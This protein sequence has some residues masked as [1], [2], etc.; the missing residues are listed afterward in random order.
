[1]LSEDCFGQLGEVGRPHTVVD[2]EPVGIGTNHGY[3]CACVT[4]S[5]WRHA[6]GCAMSAVEHDVQAAETVGETAQQV[7][8][9]D[10]FCIGETTDTADIGTSGLQHR[11]NKVALNALLDQVGE[12]HAAAGK[13]LD[14]VVGCGI[15]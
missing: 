15:V 1:M 13:N 12:L 11:A 9:I 10:V 3:P 7:Q 5:F 2:V 14:A 8:H 6:C 4:E